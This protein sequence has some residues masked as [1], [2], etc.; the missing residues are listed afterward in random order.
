MTLRTF[1]EFCYHYT[2]KKSP[3]F[4][5]VLF[6]TKNLACMPPCDS[7]FFFKYALSKEPSILKITIKFSMCFVSVEN[8][9][10]YRVFHFVEGKK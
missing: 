2:E 8:W 4:T 10:W 9:S 6:T 7:I 3:T 5:E 1:A